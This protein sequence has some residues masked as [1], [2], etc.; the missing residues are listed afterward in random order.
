GYTADDFLSGK[1]RWIDIVEPEDARRI[2]GER[3]EVRSSPN[4]VATREYRIYRKNGDMRWI[5]DVFQTFPDHAGRLS[6]VQGAV[7]D[8]TERKQA[9]EHRRNMEA[10]I[11]QAQKMEAIGTLAGGIAHD[12]NNI[13]GGIVAYTELSL[14][15]LDPSHPAHQHLKQVLKAG[16][17]AKHLVKQIL[18]FSRQGEQELRPIRV[19]PVVKEALKLLRSSLPTTIEIRQQVSTQS[20]VILA[21]ITQIHQVIMNLC[22]NAGHAMRYTGG[23]LTVR[24]SDVESAEEV[25]KRHPEMQAGGFLKITVQDSGIGMTEDVAKRIFD[26]FFTTKHPGEGTGMGLAVVHG[27][28]SMLGGDITVNSTPQKGTTFEIIFPTVAET[29]APETESVQP[30]PGGNEHILLIDDEISLVDPLKESLEM[31]GYTVTAFYNSTEA[32]KAFRADPQSF[33]VVI[34]DQTMPKLTGTQLAK[35]MISIQ[36][37]IPIILC[38]GFSE[39]LSEDRAR[40]LGIRKFVMKPVVVRDL[41]TII[42]KVLDNA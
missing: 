39:V 22:S 29:V 3:Q 28:V 34:T 1:I 30:I 36:G 4:L 25:V 38:T 10:Q 32:L 18:A 6:V 37:D 8:I 2:K 23:V 35:E 12:F 15:E 7:Y 41:A 16:D 20:D 42:R 33:D 11:R 24:L 14:L 5:S 19:S 40:A 9:E 31:I 17:R 26:P 21:D 27:I 13:L